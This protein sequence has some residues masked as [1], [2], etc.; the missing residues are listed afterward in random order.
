MTAA[1]EPSPITNAFK[2]IRRAREAGF[3]L[4]VMDGHIKSL[5]RGSLPP[6][7]RDFIIQNPATVA[8]ALRLIAPPPARVV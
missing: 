4:F 2:I 5:G 1:F 6:R 7:I 8:K 3:V